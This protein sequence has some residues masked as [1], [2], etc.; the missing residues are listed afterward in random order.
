MP[1]FIIVGGGIIG[2]MTARELRRSG[3]EV[4]LIERQQTG[5]ESSWAGGGIISPLFPW[6]YLDSVTRLASW[7]Q[8]HYPDYCEAL[9]RNTQI[10]PEYTRSGLLMVAPDEADVAMGWAQQHDRELRL[11]DD[12]EFAELEPQAADTPA[13]AIWMENVA[14]LRNP[15]FGKA[16]RA[17]IEA[18]GVQVRTDTPVDSLNCSDGQC[19]GVTTGTGTIEGDAVIVCAG[20][21]SN[22]VLAGLPTPPDIRPVRGQMILYRTPPGTITRMVLEGGRYVI[23]RRDGRV[24]FGSTMEET[25]FDKQTTA[26]AR[27]EL[28]EIAEARFPV[29]RE[30]EIER[31]WAGLRPGSPAGVPYI[32]AHP[33][34]SGLYVNAGQYRNGIVLG[35]ASAHL[36][37]DLA[38][39]RKPIVD[40]APYH[41]TAARG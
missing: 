36:A 6:R 41:W 18:E 7:S 19:R 40:P 34:I 20:A 38:L 2:M 26:A 9:A 8:Q 13:T 29:L 16:V 11:V 31:Q 39:G 32:S 15:R 25:G 30:Y 17:A 3:A 35:L 5:R 24:L 10:D 23:P 1:R 33:E 12:D 27:L 22:S 21:W 14:Q 37:A 4:I 28:R